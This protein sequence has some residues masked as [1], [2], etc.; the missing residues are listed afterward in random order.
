MTFAQFA[1]T[2]VGLIDWVLVPLIFALAFFAFLWGILNYFI[3]GA[4]DETKREEGKQ[5]LIYGLLGLVVLFSVWG[6]V[7]VVLFTFGI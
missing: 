4:T 6:L 5:F 7:N 1:N 3:I 2:I